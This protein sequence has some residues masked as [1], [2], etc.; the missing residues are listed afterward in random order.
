[1]ENGERTKESTESESCFDRHEKV[2]ENRFE[3]QEFYKNS[4]SATS[5]PTNL[6]I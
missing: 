5:F 4:L 6:M 1:M 2:E 3:N